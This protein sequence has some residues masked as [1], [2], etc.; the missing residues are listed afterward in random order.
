MTA[1]LLSFYTF[2][3]TLGYILTWVFGILFTI[4]F[5]YAMVK[6]MKP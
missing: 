5:I 4:M 1:I 6:Y 2:G 3:D